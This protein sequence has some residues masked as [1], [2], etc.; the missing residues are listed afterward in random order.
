VF[1]IVPIVVLVILLPLA[2]L[3]RIGKK[4]RRQVEADLARVRALRPSE[5]KRLA[6]QL[7]NSGGDWHARPASSPASAPLPPAVADILRE[8]EEVVRDEFWIGRSALSEPA[9]VGGLVKIGGD[10]EFC[11]LMVKPTGL[12]VYSSYGDSEPGEVPEVSPTIWHK[13]LEVA[14]F[15]V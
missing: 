2:I 14:E 15:K 4:E 13:I 5:A 6:L 3:L 8:Y 7:L 12:T 11:E 9:R 1:W 10:S